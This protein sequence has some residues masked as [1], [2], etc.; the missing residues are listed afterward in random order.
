LTASNEW[1]TTVAAAS[2]RTEIEVARFKTHFWP[3]VCQIGMN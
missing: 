2:Q 3:L 1:T